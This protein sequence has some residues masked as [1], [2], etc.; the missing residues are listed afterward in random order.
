MWLR[1]GD[2]GDGGEAEWVLLMKCTVNE[3]VPD[4]RKCKKC[5]KNNH[6]PFCRKC[7]KFSDSEQCSVAGIVGEGGN[8]ARTWPYKRRRVWD[9]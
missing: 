7:S 6:I 8:I 3:C 1:D 9:I 2:G 4:C 5:K